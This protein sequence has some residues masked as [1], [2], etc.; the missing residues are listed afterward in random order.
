MYQLRLYIVDA[1][2]SSTQAI[3]EL[4]AL[5]E[6]KFKGQYSLKIIDVLTNP[7][8]GEADKILAT[9]T[10]IKVMPAPERRIVGSMSDCEKVMAGLELM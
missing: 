10:V 8:L 7:E 1:S 5:L 2:K 6:D 9:P 4:E 3:Q